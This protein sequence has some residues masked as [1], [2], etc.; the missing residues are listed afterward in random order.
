MATHSSILIWRIPGIRSLAGY[1]LWGRK[2][3]DT[4][5][6]LHFS[7]SLYTGWGFPG[8]S[9]G[10]ESASNAGD[11]SLIYGLG[12]SLGEGISYPIQYSWA[13]LVAQMVKN[14]PLWRPGFYPWVRTIPLRRAWE[15]ISVLLPGESP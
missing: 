10:K 5:E 3:S 6:Q 13:S 8:G 9:D 4:T 7:L 15:P 11:P 12:T 2:E 14:L 1:S